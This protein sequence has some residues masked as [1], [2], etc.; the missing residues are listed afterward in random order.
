MSPLCQHHSQMLWL[1][2]IFITTLFVPILANEKH[3]CVSFKGQGTY[4]WQHVVKIDTEHNLSAPLKDLEASFVSWATRQFMWF[5]FFFYHPLAVNVVWRN[6]WT[7]IQRYEGNLNKCLRQWKLWYKEFTV[8]NNICAH[9]WL[10]FC[11]SQCARTQIMFTC[12][13]MSLLISLCSYKC[14]LCNVSVVQIGIFK[15]IDKG[16]EKWIRWC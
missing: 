11:H 12:P 4:P 15:K 3:I 14:E 13:D 1:R 7:A 5:L 10:L 2:S 8:A 6:G 16:Y 9:H